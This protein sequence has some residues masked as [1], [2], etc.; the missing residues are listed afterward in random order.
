MGGGGADKKNEISQSNRLSCGSK[1]VVT[2]IPPGGGGLTNLETFTSQTLTSVYRATGLAR[3]PY[4]SCKRDKKNENFYRRGGLPQ[5][6][7]LHHPPG[8]PHLH[9]NRPLFSIMFV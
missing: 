7:V 9:V 8:V 6:T 4:L 5:L 2:P 1:I 3:S